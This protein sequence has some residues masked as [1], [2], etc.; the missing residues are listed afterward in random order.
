MKIPKLQFRLATVF[1]A[2]TLCGMVMGT[3]RYYVYVNERIHYHSQLREQ[4]NTRMQN[5]SQLLT[6][7]QASREPLLAGDEDRLDNLS[8]HYVFG[9]PLEIAYIPAQLA[10][11]DKEISLLKAEY[12]QEE[13]V[14][15][16][17]VQMITEFENSRWR[18]WHRVAELASP[19]VS[20]DRAA[21]DQPAPML[22][23]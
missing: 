17:H 12:A 1:V 11:V 14:K 5:R 15:N 18:P 13:T 19:P 2:L 22:G 21:A 4:A 8:E 6:V 9:Q 7:F 10:A 23:Q 20:M 16:Y 3:Y